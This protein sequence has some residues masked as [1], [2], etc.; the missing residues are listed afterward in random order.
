MPAAKVVTVHPRRLD[1]ARALLLVVSMPLLGCFNPDPIRVATDTDDA[2][3]SG[4]DT[5]T[6]TTL[7]TTAPTTEPTGNPST[8]D[9]TMDPDDSSS[10]AGTACEVPEDCPAPDDCEVATCE[11]GVCAVVPADA[12]TPCGDDADDEC[13]AP[14]TCDGKGACVANDAQDGTA[15]TDCDLGQCSCDAGECGDCSFAPANNFITTRAIA[16]W[17]LTGGWALYREVPQ[18]ERGVAIRMESQVLGT[19][20][21]RSQPYPGGELEDSHARSAE[22]TLPATLDLLSWHIDEGGGGSYDN[23][24][25]A[26]SVDDGA[27]WVVVA[28]CFIDPALPFCVQRME[29]AADDW[30][31][32]SIPVPADMVGERGR[33]EL[34]YVSGD[35]CCEWERGW[36]VD[37]LEFATECGCGD[38]ATCAE[39]GSECGDPVCGAAGECELDPVAAGTGCGD[40]SASQCD[41]LDACDGAGYCLTNVAATG[42]TFCTECPAGDGACQTC[43]QG[44]C[45]DCTALAP[46]NDFANTTLA[47]L[48]WVVESLDGGEPDWRTYNE[49]PLNRLAGSVPVFLGT[50]PA[51]GTDGNRVAPYDVMAD[52]FNIE[53]EFSRVTTTPDVVAS[54]LT[55]DSWNVDEGTT[56]IKQIEISVDGGVSWTMLADCTS[57]PDPFPF[58]NYVVDGRAGDVWDPVA[59]DVS[60]FAGLVGQLRFTYNTQ[61]ACCDFERGWFIDNL[62]FAQYCTDPQFP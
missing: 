14:D 22:T 9:S 6:S 43:Q 25:I 37:V 24:S 12:D 57:P 55:F 53:S 17:E 8:V 16:G 38:D 31:T 58:C 29:R 34:R 50:A 20:G 23:K 54:P 39:L 52:P 45:S 2:S 13:T 28:D 59:I 46:L 35:D 44:T 62:S 1:H 11:A 42:L 48:G 19:D 47:E 3:E 5:P 10:T 56:D 41:A 30:D 4:T 49:A 21:N 40:D 18:S 61:D 15:C 7:E 32:L 27:T 51:F 26:V 33:V 36:Y 60:A